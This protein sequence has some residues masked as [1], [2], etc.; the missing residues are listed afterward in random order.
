MGSRTPYDVCVI[1]SGA[2]GGVMAKELAQG[3]AETL[4]IEAGPRIAMKELRSHA[5]P[6]ELPYRGLRG[7]RQAP[8]YPAELTK[9]ISYDTRDEVSVDRIRVVGGRTVH[10]NA[11]CLRFAEADF[12]E[13][14]REGIEED[15]PI[16]YNELAP[17]YDRVET[18][19]G[20]TGT[21]E[22]LEILPDGKFL[23]PL[24][25]RCSEQILKGACEKLGYRLIPTRKAL[26]T[27]PYDGRPACHYCGHCMDGCDV[28]A[29]FNT[30]TAMIPKAERTGH[31]TLRADTLAR[32]LLVDRRGQV[33]AVSV[34]D[35]ITKKEEEIK[36]RIFVVSC[37]TIESARLLLNSRSRMFPEGLANSS[38][39]VGRH[40]GGHINC[41][42]LGYLESLVGTKSINRDGATDHALIPRFN[43]NDK[44]R[45]Y[46]GGFHYQMQYAGFMFPHHARHLAGFGPGFKREVRNLQP[47]FINIGGW[48]KVLARPENRVTVDPNR[49]DAYGI[50][51][52]VIHFN[53]CENDRALWRD[54]CSKAEE[55]LHAAGVRRLIQATPRPVGF[56]SH[57]VGT[58]RMGHDP[59]KSVL[60]PYCRSHDVRNL[61]VVDTSCFVT[62]PEKNP[63]HTIMAL[64]VRTAEYIRRQRSRGE[65]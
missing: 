7:E 35:R 60:N 4:L 19:V 43:M 46:V 58:V 23:K 49:P 12:R 6:Y 8:L 33:R 44:K 13:R 48:G 61:F 2:A 53:F 9:A 24:R 63:T 64:A 45:G 41:S 40:L 38:G 56:T 25:L 20:V 62:F 17:Y 57:E 27:E 32:E 1:G 22:G 5:W 54:M 37:A 11:V 39:L 29:I 47:G 50:P 18:M 30:A 55:I 26:L 28:E 14:T 42:Y 34:I 21:R 36:A 3:G 65:L 31:F 52:P 10:W 16:S 51:I 59:V 15:W